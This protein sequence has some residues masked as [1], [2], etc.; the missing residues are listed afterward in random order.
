MLVDTAR[1]TVRGQENPQ[2]IKRKWQIVKNLY[3]KVSC[4]GTVLIELHKYLCLTLTEVK[5]PLSFPNSS[6][7]ICSIEHPAPPSYKVE[8]ALF[9]A[10]NTN[11]REHFKWKHYEDHIRQVWSTVK[12]SHTTLRGRTT[13]N[14]CF[15]FKHSI[16]SVHGLALN[17]M[18]S[19]AKLH[20]LLYQ[21]RILKTCGTSQP[22]NTELWRVLLPTCMLCSACQAHP[23]AKRCVTRG[24][25]TAGKGPRDPSS[26]N[27]HHKYSDAG[28]F[29]F[30][31]VARCYLQILISS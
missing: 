6:A 25:A 4:L 29:V 22:T 16:I 30:L 5:N 23:S 18:K 8:S 10:T 1:G 24:A 19:Q 26:G 17:G 28:W 14:T 2:L 3:G 7:N 27:H 9:S 21:Q 11:H 15:L 20:G 13:F 12:H 31:P